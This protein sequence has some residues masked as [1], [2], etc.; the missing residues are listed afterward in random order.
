MSFGEC[1][2]Y[3]DGSHYIAIPYVP[4]PRKKKWKPP[5][6]M[7]VVKEEGVSATEI[8]ETDNAE[9]PIETHE[10]IE[11]EVVPFGE[12]EN[13]DKPQDVSVSKAKKE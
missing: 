7:I 10:I 3:N 11:N 6:E 12:P 1:K 5:E 2:V 4:N 13:T 8:I 9:N